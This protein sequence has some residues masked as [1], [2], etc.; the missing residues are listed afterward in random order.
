MMATVTQYA[1]SNQT[2]SRK[3]TLEPHRGSTAPDEID[4]DNIKQFLEEHAEHNPELASVT[5][6]VDDPVSD[7]ST[8][9]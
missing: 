3:F 8:T 7:F 6:K 5:F 4:I 1:M 2:S 9:N